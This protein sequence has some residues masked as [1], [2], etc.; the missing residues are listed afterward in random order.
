MHLFTPKVTIRRSDEDKLEHAEFPTSI[1]AG[2]LTGALVQINPASTTLARNGL[3]GARWMLADGTI[4]SVYLLTR[5]V[6]SSTY[7]TIPLENIVYQADMQTPQLL[8]EQVTGLKA[9]NCIV[10]F[11]G[12]DY[13]DV[14]GDGAIS[15]GTAINSELTCTAGKIALKSQVIGEFGQNLATVG[16][17][18]GF[19]TPE[20]AGNLRIVVEF[21][22][23][24]VRDRDTDTD[25]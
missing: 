15:S 25:T 24:P 18:L 8:G 10:E 11:E 13:I 1:T 2:A 16:R 7:S 14:A 22:A 9:A 20:T 3:E 23:F 4:G 6:L 17:L 5:E 12:T 19:A 21:G